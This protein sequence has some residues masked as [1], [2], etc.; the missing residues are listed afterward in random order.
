MPRTTKMSQDEERRCRACGWVIGNGWCWRCTEDF[1]RRP[2][3]AKMT[4]EEKRQELH[5]LKTRP[6]DI[7]MR[8]VVKRMQDLSGRRIFQTG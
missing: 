6:P 4:A 1:D 5:Q 3:L 2:D 7:D 8:K